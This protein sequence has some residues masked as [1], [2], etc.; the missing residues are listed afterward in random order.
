L[1]LAFAAIEL[2]PLPIVVVNKKIVAIPA[3]QDILSLALSMV[4]AQ[5]VVAG[6]SVDDVTAPPSGDQVRRAKAAYLVVSLFTIQ[7]V[8]F[9][10]A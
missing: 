8:R 5:L 3:I 7:L 10:G 9:V 4:C 2:A 6:A 1:V